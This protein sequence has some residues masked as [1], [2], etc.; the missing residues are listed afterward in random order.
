MKVFREL[1]ISGDSAVIHKTIGM[2]QKFLVK[3]WTRDTQAEEQIKPLSG[4]MYSFACSM[5]PK[6]QAAHLWLAAND[7]GGYYVSS[8]VPDDVSR[9]SVDEYNLILEEFHQKIIVPASVETGAKVEITKPEETL[10]DWLSSET[11]S[12]L[13]KF[14][15]LANKGTGRGHA[16]D[17]ERWFEFIVAAY[18]EGAKLTSSQLEHWLIEDEGWPED[19]AMELSFDYEY[20]RDLLKFCDSKR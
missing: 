15:A 19:T 4:K 3:G 1:I 2:L 14:S 17:E 16:L 6:R 10:E 7:G 9:L 20:S 8:I 18:K 5:T 11:A 13:K 12:L